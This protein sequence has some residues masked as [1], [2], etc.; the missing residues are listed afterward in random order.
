MPPKPA[1]PSQDM[2][3]RHEKAVKMEATVDGLLHHGALSQA[4][5]VFDKNWAE[6]IL[7]SLPLRQ[8]FLLERPDR[9]GFSRL[10]DLAEKGEKFDLVLMRG[11]DR[12]RKKQIAVG[13]E[14]EGLVVGW[15]PEEMLE[16]LSDAGD[17]SGLYQPGILAARGL[18]TGTMQFEMELIRPDL[19]QCSHCNNLHVGQHENCKECRQKRRPKKRSLEETVEAPAVPVSQ[20]FHNIAE[21]AHSKKKAG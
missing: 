12:R 3:D 7:A 1:T 21:A 18:Q 16:M 11:V 13:I 10:L 4:Q 6:T 8:A 9:A 5:R 2:K 15:L 17:Y 19:R 14:G 20:A